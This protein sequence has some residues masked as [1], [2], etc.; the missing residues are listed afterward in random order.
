MTAKRR[1]SHP[2]RRNLKILPIIYFFIY[3]LPYTPVAVVIFEKLAGS[4]VEAMSVFS[5]MGLT[6][7][8]LEVPTGV[9]SDKWGRRTTLTVGCF[10]SFLNVACLALACHSEHPLWFMY[11]AALL[12]GGAEAL[13]SGNNE[14]IVYESLDSV[15][16]TASFP[17]FNGRMTSM[18]QA[19]LTVSAILSALILITGWPLEILIYV[20]LVTCGTLVI[21]TR[22]LIEPPDRLISDK[23]P[24]KHFV[25]AFRL[26]KKNERLRLYSLTNMLQAGAM[27]S[28]YYIMPG[29]IN[30]VWPTWAVPFLRVGQHLVG[31]FSFWHS[32]AI[33]KALGAVR[34][35]VMLPL[36]SNG[37]SL[38]AFWIGNIFSPFLLMLAPVAYAAWATAKSTLEQESFSK[39]QRATMG[40]LISLGGSVIAALLS[41]LMGWMAD[42]FS[43]GMTLF[44]VMAA[45]TIIVNGSYTL[46][47]RRHK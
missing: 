25:E 24:Y 47:Y 38:V 45:R 10:L 18:M 1:K 8:V 14:A 33:V 11:A 4:Y 43:I 20:S 12:Q 34:T 9:L 22:F 39:E 44:L 31:T 42:Y 13:Y 40:S 41:L 26:I 17:K 35:L 2:A 7:A 28:N 27:S 37:M 19:G 16:K 36:L 21:L 29:F 32:G 3:L 5:L 30:A 23:H 46:I 15:K 6:G